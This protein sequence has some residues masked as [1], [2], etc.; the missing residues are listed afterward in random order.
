MHPGDTTYAILTTN[1]LKQIK[2]ASVSTCTE[3]TILEVINI[4]GMV[5]AGKSTLIKV[6]AF[7]CYKNGCRM[8]IVVDTVAEVMN[9][10]KYL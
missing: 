8:T 2:E 7:W 5:G 10:Q 9:L 6:L 4:V 3:L 1:V